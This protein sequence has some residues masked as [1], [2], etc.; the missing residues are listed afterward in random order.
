MSET[1]FSLSG[2]SEAP[3]FPLAGES[4]PVRT[5][6]GAE[7][8]AGQGSRSW[9]E[10]LRWASSFPAMLGMLLVGVAFNV[11]RQLSLDPDV[12]WHI[13]DGEAI[14]ATHHW[15]TTD[16]YSFTVHGFPWI[17]FEWLGDV[18][19]ATALR[20]GGVQGLQLLMF[21]LGSAI[22]I[23]LYALATICS[24]KSKAGFAAAVLLTPMVIAQFNLR[25]QMLGYLLLVLA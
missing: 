8:E 11:A 7:R 22:L 10:A 4:A 9:V 5:A 14:L 24:G 3:G 20:L 25:P 15:P 23:A 18:T 1:N 19:L 12:W 17:A 16:P 21:F 6:E 13:K 2:R